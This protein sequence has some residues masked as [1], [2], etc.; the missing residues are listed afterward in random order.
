MESFF[1]SN[2]NIS[3]T[4]IGTDALRRNWQLFK[5]GVELGLAL[6]SQARATASFSAGRVEEMEAQP[7]HVPHS[8]PTPNTL[9]AVLATESR[10][11]GNPGLGIG[12]ETVVDVP[13]H[14]EEVCT[15][16]V[17]R[18]L[19]LIYFVPLDSLH[20]VRPGLSTRFEY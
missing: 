18:S 1:F 17:N 13:N 15:L 16:R 19:I 5:W 11:H 14:D 3:N 6:Y 2:T 12:P 8:A 9:A 10:I 20:R 7:Q 4:S